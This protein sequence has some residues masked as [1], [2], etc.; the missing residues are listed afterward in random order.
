MGSMVKIFGFV[1]VLGLV[2]MDRAHAYID[3][4]TGSMLLQALLAC[5]VAV[6]AFGRQIWTRISCFMSSRKED[7]DP[8]A[9]ETRKGQE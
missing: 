9:D 8:E 3:P 2:F 5:L 4:G 6:I 1:V 7:Q